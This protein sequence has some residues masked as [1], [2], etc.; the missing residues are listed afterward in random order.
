MDQ[1]EYAQFRADSY[2]HSDDL[3]H[4]Y[5][6]LRLNGYQ[7]FVKNYMSI[8]TTNDRLL[9]VHSTGVGKTITSLSTAIEHMKS[10]NRNVFI[11]GFSKSVFKREL[12]TRPEFG[13]VHKDEVALM[14]TLNNDLMR[15]GKTRTANKLK[16]V[17]RRVSARLSKGSNRIYF[18]GYKALINAMFIRT[19]N[20]IN[21][22]E[23]KS[24]N[25]IK[26]FLAKKQIRPNVEFMRLV[27]ESFI[28]CDE[29]HNLYNAKALNSWG[30]CLKYLIDTSNCKAMFLSATPVNNQPEKIVNVINLLVR[31]EYNVSDLFQGNK[32]TDKGKQIVIDAIKG[33]VSYLIDRDQSKFPDKEFYGTTIDYLK[34][35]L[36]PAPAAQVTSYKSH[37]NILSTN[38]ENDASHYLSSDELLAENV[39]QYSSKYP[40]ILELLS[41]EGKIFM[42]HNFVKS[43]TSQ[44]KEL[45]YINGMTEYG[46]SPSPN[47]RCSRCFKVSKG[48]SDHK[49]SPYYFLYVTGEVSKTELSFGLSLFNS[50]ENVNGDRIKLIIGSQAIKESYDF[51][52]V[53][54]LI[55]A[56]MP[57]NIST[58]IQVL[59]RAIRKNSH[60]DLPKSKRKVNIYLLATTFDDIESYE[61]NRYKNKMKTF[62]EIKTLNQLF[63]EYA[64]D[65]DSNF[66]I[67][68]KSNEEGIFEVP[69]VSKS[70]DI[71]KIKSEVFSAY[72]SDEEVMLCLYIIKRVMSEAYP[73]G[74]SYDKL[75]K[76]VRET[77]L[78]N[79]DPLL[80][81]E[82]SIITAIAAL[83]SDS[84]VQHESHKT[85][86]FGVFDQLKGIPVR[87]G[88]SFYSMYLTLCK[89]TYY[90]SHNGVQLGEFDFH[91][92]PG[93]ADSKLIDLNK[94]TSMNSNTLADRE[95]WISKCESTPIEFISDA[96]ADPATHLSTITYIIEY[97]SDMWLRQEDWQMSEHHD[98]LVKL[99]FFYNKFRIIIWGSQMNKQ[100]NDMYSVYKEKFTRSKKVFFTSSES[101]YEG[102]EDMVATVDSIVNIFEDIKKEEKLKFYYYHKNKAKFIPG[103]DIP[104]ASLI[105]VGHYFSKEVMILSPDKKWIKQSAINNNLHSVYRENQKI[106]GFLEKDRDGLNVAFK[107]RVGPSKE[108]NDQRKKITGSICETHERDSLVKVCKILKIDSA[109]NKSKLCERIKLKLI[110]LELE[111]RKNESAVR[112]FKFYWEDT[113]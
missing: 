7:N 45:C 9:L 40:K 104:K 21:L 14:K 51:K 79:R 42:Y 4:E 23:L 52:A 32:L 89:G 36:C 82:D 108:H 112:Y 48:H 43:G 95:E 75:L 90:L 3:I 67:N 54:N 91:R 111:A 24:T 92:P 78:A 1:K 15:D 22:D 56:F 35:M 18:I 83:A 73:A 101:R 5:G 66:I 17:R 68:S 10:V 97:F 60:S 57:D 34:F 49:F 39:S 2:S 19:S 25:D 100:V 71:H 88:N 46:N 109:G 64:I 44:L 13:F 38:I 65:K 103:D 6:L 110:N 69:K 70:L 27:K 55:V 85:T 26:F 30:A 59:G 99:L 93:L 50:V 29:V 72:Y 105:P 53:Q 81:S 107:I 76:R 16:E 84:Y 62:T 37:A 58:L 63:A 80:I 74:L 8:N 33:K 113:S 77:K 96:N 47:A 31:E 98:T 12:I 94:V 11:I 102:Y 61:I 87:V 28:I 106:L 20:K 41:N 86:L